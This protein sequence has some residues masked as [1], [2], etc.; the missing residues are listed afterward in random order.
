MGPKVNNYD[1]H[2]HPFSLKVRY[3]GKRRKIPVAHQ[4]FLTGFGKSR[5]IASF[6]ALYEEEI[7]VS[8]NGKKFWIPAQKQVVPYL[9]QELK[10]GDLFWIY[11]RYF[12]SAEY[13]RIFCLVDFHSGR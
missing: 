4:S 7:Q 13:D 2:T 8:E 11:V 9:D 5:Q 6:V 10:T 3:E 1:F 12:G